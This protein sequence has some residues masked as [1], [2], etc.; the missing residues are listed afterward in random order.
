MKRKTGVRRG[1]K[2]VRLEASADV[3]QE[4]FTKGG[5]A[6]WREERLELGRWRSLPKKRVTLKL[7]ADVVAWFRGKGRGYQWQIN[8]AL[9]KAMESKESGR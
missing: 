6:A 9:R 2:F 5:W 1:G 4:R 8:R 3:E 7:D